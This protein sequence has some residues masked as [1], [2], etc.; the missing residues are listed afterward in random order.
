MHQAGTRLHR[1]QPFATQEVVSLVHQRHMHGDEVAGRQQVV[2]VVHAHALRRAGLGDEGV[3]SR[4]G[5]PEPA[6]LVG[7]DPAD[8]AE[9]HDT[10]LLVLQLDA[11]EL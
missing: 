7:D 5:H 6:A 8:A 9:P 2:E 1:E 10:E 3:V 11:C 4:D